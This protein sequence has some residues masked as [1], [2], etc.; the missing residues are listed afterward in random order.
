MVE[1][2]RRDVSLSRRVVGGHS[3]VAQCQNARLGS[4]A[5]TLFGTQPPGH[6][7]GRGRARWTGR[8][9]GE[10]EVSKQRDDRQQEEAEQQSSRANSHSCGNRQITDYLPRP[11]LTEL[12]TGPLACT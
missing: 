6:Q 12:S 10:M 8:R 2:P 3:G 4:R 5:A 7:G 11:A 1:Q 9:G